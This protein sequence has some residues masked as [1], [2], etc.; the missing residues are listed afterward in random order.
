MRFFFNFRIEELNITNT[1]G[2][3]PKFSTLLSGFFSTMDPMSRIFAFISLFLLLTSCTVGD[4][5]TIEIIGKDL[6]TSEIRIR[7]MGV[8]LPDGSILTSDHVVRD[9]IKYEISSIVY[10]L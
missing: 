2:I 4:Y 3:F 10:Y 8:R 6:T 5:E 9:G 1:V 7:G